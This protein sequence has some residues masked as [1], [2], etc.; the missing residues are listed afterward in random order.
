[1]YIKSQIDSTANYGQGNVDKEAWKLGSLKSLE[2]ERS[3]VVKV[4]T[5]A[6]LLSF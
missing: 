3:F 2:A 1:L 4:L 6:Q 5:V